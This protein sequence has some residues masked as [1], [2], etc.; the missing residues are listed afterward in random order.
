MGEE[1][2]S[3]IGPVL[4]GLARRAIGQ[5]LGVAVAVGETPTAEVAAALEAPGAAFVTLTLGG[6]LRGCI[7][8]LVA[9]RPLAD[10]VAD[11]A[12]AAAFRD[13]RFPELS[14]AEF[15]PLHVEVSVLSAPQPM[16]FGSQAEALA[17]LR[18]GVDGVIFEAGWARSTFLP[19]V[20]E[21]LPEPEVFM[22]HL[23]RK[24]GL[25]AAYWG[26]DVRLSRYTVTAFEEP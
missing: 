2:P 1:L 24:A 22:A 8:S 16:V 5:R 21:Q 12:V 6:Q 15:E 9:H 18:P 25:P 17:A 23:K 20:W 14:V 13:P 11:N 7:G 10:D 4:T 3:G 26:P 19:Q